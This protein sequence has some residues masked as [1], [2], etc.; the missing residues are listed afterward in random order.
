MNERGGQSTRDSRR[1]LRDAI[2]RLTRSGI[3]DA[4]ARLDAE[5]LLAEAIGIT[6]AQLLSSAHE[7]GHEQGAY[8]L[9]MVARRAA[10]M[11]LAYILGRREFFSMEFKVDS[12]VLIPRP[13][14]EILVTAA[15]DFAAARKGLRILEI[16]TGSGAVAIALALHI[17]DVHVVATDISA[18]AL[19]I[20]RSNARRLGAPASIDFKMADCWQLMDDNA[21]LGRFDLIVS[22][23]PYIAEDE[24][25]RL[26]PEV[27]DYEPK[28][29]LTPGSDGLSFHGR[30]AEG[31]AE[32]LTPEGAVLLELGCGQA[33]AVIEILKSAGFASARLIED[34]AGIPRVVCANL[35]E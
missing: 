3:T 26:E 28:A 20:A 7:L 13:E 14:T 35:A 18:S 29:A 30:I 5:I 1:L 6:R 9:D 21:I 8:F 2:A 32:H 27:R 17:P 34:L 19:E 22:N 25:E 16:G 12:N 10:R 4:D 11:P 24:L 15:V 31:L 33:Q 23:P